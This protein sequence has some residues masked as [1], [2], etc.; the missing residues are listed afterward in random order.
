VCV[1][2]PANTARAQGADGAERGPPTYPAFVLFITACVLAPLPLPIVSDGSHR[3]P[4][5]VELAFGAHGAEL[6]ARDP[7]VLDRL[8][9][10]SV[11]GH[12]GLPW[13]A[14][15]DTTPPVT[16]SPR[17]EDELVPADVRV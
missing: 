13:E 3:P 4:S 8:V 17:R 12:A 11:F 9:R 10:R 16:P 7:G 5:A 14:V 1:L 15:A 6:Y 2:S